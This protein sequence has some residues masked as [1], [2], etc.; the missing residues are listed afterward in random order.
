M[1][2][3]FFGGPAAKNLHLPFCGREELWEKGYL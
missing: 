2:S 3:S 1:V